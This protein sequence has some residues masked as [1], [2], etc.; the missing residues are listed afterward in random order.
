MTAPP[1]NLIQLYSIG[2]AIEQGVA[3][4]SQM[5]GAETYKSYFSN[6]ARAIGEYLFAGPLKGWI[7]MGL[8]IARDAV[9]RLASYAGGGRWGARR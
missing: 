5:Q 4:F 7:G 1:G 2:W 3:A 6:E 8:F 9:K